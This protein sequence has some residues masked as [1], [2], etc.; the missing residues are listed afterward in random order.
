MLHAA[1][2]NMRVLKQP[3]VATNAFAQGV[4]VR[5]P[6]VCSQRASLTHARRACRRR[7]RTGGH[8]AQLDAVRGQAQPRGLPGL[9]AGRAHAPRGPLLCAPAPP[10]GARLHAREP[11]P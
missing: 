1:H 3:V 9:V 7:A 6:A 10:R 8:C 4:W 5:D 2:L 11:I